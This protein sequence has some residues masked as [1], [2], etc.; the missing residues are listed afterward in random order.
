MTRVARLTGPSR[1]AW[2]KAVEQRIAVTSSVLRAMK[3][4]KMAGL[5]DLM[6]L[7]IQD[8][9]KREM[10]LSK[11]FRLLNSVTNMIGES[12]SSRKK[13]LFP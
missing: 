4:I 11:K 13:I 9:R 3:A 1:A 7:K 12:Y 2:N 5:S 6:K 10:K 8:M